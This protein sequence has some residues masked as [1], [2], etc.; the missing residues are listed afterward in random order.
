LAELSTFEW[1]EDKNTINQ[2]KHGIAFE[3]AQY[4]F[5]DSH[6][7]IA[8]DLE[9]SDVED[10]STVLAKSIIMWRL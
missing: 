2:R 5:S 4:A 7:I 1:D 9:H 6:R 3:E 10:R 8:K